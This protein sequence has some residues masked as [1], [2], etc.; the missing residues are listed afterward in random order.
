MIIQNKLQ[1]LILS[2]IGLLIISLILWVRIVRYLFK[3]KTQFVFPL[4][5]FKCILI[6]MVI[7]YAYNIY[8]VFLFLICK[9]NKTLLFQHIA[10][11]PIIKKFILNLQLIKESPKIFYTTIIY[12]HVPVVFLIEK[13][14]FNLVKL[15][16]HKHKDFIYF[17]F[18]IFPRSIVSTLFLLSI[19]QVIAATTFV[20]S[21]FLLL[22]PLFYN[23]YYYM[24]KH[25]CDENIPYFKDHLIIKKSDKKGML[26]VEFVNIIP[27]YPDAKDI[28]THKN[29]KEL[30]NWFISNYNIYTNIRNFLIRLQIVENKYKNY[31]NLYVY[32]CYFIGWSYILYFL[33]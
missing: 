9:N 25:F 14:T 28:I 1:Q 32:S 23:C 5:F 11:Y 31:E 30:L 15:F 4:G 13:P 6:F 17:L 16:A 21:L 29:N 27:N 7:F 10:K 22:L 19:F 3:I 33:L 20:S 18:I 24:A 12:P 26:H 8:I 2:F